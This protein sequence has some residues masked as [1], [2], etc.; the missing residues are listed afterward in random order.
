MTAF[1]KAQTPSFVTPI[2]G[3]YGKDFFIVNYVDYKT[4]SANFKDLFCNTKT[5]EGHQGTDFVI[6]SFAQMD[7][8]VNVLAVDDGEVIFVE[9][10]L[11]DR[12]TE[13]IKS[14][15]FGNYIA[16]KHKNKIHTYYAHL[17][18][19]SALVK[20]GEKVIAGQ[21]IAQ[22]GSSGNSSDPHLHFEV[23]YD[24][25]NYIDPTVYSNYFSGE[26][27]TNALLLNDRQK[28]LN[29]NHSSTIGW[30]RGNPANKD[31]YFTF[32]IKVA[33]LL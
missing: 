27:L 22:V 7:S 29:P 19:N 2:E 4:D 10:S 13:S 3:T 30:Q 9:D 24:S 16:I 23:W 20:V 8:G 21:K 12:N 28:E 31:S 26:Q 11:F 1:I 5:Y 6:R 33:A 15:G 32:N 18:K 25:T 14:L 17:R